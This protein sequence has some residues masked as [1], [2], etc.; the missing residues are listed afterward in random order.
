MYDLF[1]ALYSDHMSLRS[2]H[3]IEPTAFQR[4]SP[5][6]QYNFFQKA[7][8]IYLGVVILVG[9]ALVIALLRTKDL[10]SRLRA[11]HEISNGAL[12]TKWQKGYRGGAPSLTYVY[13]ID[14]KRFS[15][16]REFKQL[17]SILEFMVNKSVPVAFETGNPDNSYPLI[18]PKDFAYFNLT[19]PDSLRWVN[20]Y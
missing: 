17:G 4:E 3:T 15:K 6:Q 10:T 2:R 5:E 16:Y 13:T 19:F 1:F 8:W 12:I 20:N 14:G 7:K 11:H 9:I 18:T